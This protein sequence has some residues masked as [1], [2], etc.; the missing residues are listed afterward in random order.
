MSLFKPGEEISVGEWVE[1]RKSEFGYQKGMRFKVIRVDPGNLDNPTEEH[2]TLEV[3]FQ[4]QL[5]SPE[6]QIEHFVC[7]GWSKFL[8][9]Y[10]PSSPENP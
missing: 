7:I 10:V 3:E 2:G 8:R 1:M 6:W 5:G 4:N 9:K